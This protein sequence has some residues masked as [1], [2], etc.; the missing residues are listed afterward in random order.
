MAD[1]R[2]EIEKLVSQLEQQRDELRLKLNLAKADARDEWDKIE[3]QLDQLR[4]RLSGARDAAG[5]SAADVGAAARLLA[6]EIRRGFD[7]IRKR[8]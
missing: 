3:K 5:Q 8:L 6:E 4:G 1:L 2:D 7:A